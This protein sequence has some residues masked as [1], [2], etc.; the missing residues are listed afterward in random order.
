MNINIVAGVF[1][2]YGG[3]PSAWAATFASELT[4][5]GATVSLLNAG[6]PEVLAAKKASLPDEG[7]V[8]WLGGSANPRE[9]KQIKAAHPKLF[10]V[11]SKD[12]LDG[13]FAF[14]QLISAAFDNKSNLL[15][16]FSG[17]A[18]KVGSTVLDPLGNIYCYNETAVSLVASAVYQRLNIITTV[19]R[20]SSQSIGASIPVSSSNDLN[21]FIKLI[22]A[23]AE[24]FHKLITPNSERMLGNA[25]FRCE[26]G[27]PSVKDGYNVFV[28]RRNVDKRTLT[29][30]EFIACTKCSPE[31]GDGYV[32]YFGDV[33]P[34][35]D[36]PIQLE[37]Y[38]FFKNVKYMVHSHA[39]V[40]GAP[41][42]ANAVPCGALEEVEEIKKLNSNPDAVN[43]CINLKG[44]GSLVLAST[45]DFIKT[46]K[47]KARRL[48]EQG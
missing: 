8:I 1:D 20:E 14:L 47:W 12:N 21:E 3:V 39:F 48:P 2:G 44:H 26:S 42:T 33:K 23:Q 45:V 35:V 41:T 28:T 19:T 40:E 24:T 17:S 18:D 7:V 11:I 46:V 15:I 29:Q 30:S 38:S 31:V 13:N 10:L 4:N 9:L 16:E 37:L 6:T 36:T 27:F 32:G 25:S 43:F 5:I 34:S 22:N